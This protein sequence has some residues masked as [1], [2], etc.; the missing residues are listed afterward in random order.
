MKKN[1]LSIFAII[2]AHIAIIISIISLKIERLGEADYIAIAATILTGAVAFAVGYNIY[3]NLSVTKNI[4]KHSAR[5]EAE[6]I[7][8]QISTRITIDHNRISDERLSNAIA[9]SSSYATS[10]TY[11]ELGNI[12]RDSGKNKEAIEHY[13]NALKYCETAKRFFVRCNHQDMIEKCDA[14]IV[15]INEKLNAI[16]N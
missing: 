11:Y 6:L 14:F 5:K 9:G 13:K 8:K 15:E 10:I 2:I 3:I 16:N 1:L 12:Q 7:A 4:A